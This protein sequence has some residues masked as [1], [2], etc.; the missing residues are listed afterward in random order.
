METGVSDELHKPHVPWIPSDGSSSDSSA[1]DDEWRPS[2]RKQTRK[3]NP[4]RSQA[5]KLI[6]KRRK[7]AALLLQK[8]MAQESATWSSIRPQD[9]ASTSSL[10]Q[11]ASLVPPTQSAQRP[12]ARAVGG[13]GP[14]PPPLQG[15]KA[16]W[17]R[18]RV[19][20]LCLAHQRD[21]LSRVLLCREAIRYP[22]CWSDTTLG[23]SLPGKGPKSPLKAKNSGKAPRTSLSTSPRKGKVPLEVRHAQPQVDAWSVA[24][25]VGQGEEPPCHNGSV[26]AAPSSSLPPRMESPLRGECGED[27]ANPGYER[28]RGPGRE[29]GVPSRPKLR[30]TLLRRKNAVVASKNTQVGQYSPLG[31]SLHRGAK[32]DA[33]PTMVATRAMPRMLSRGNYATHSELAEHGSGQRPKAVGGHSRSLGACK[34]PAKLRLKRSN[35]ADCA[36][37][38]KLRLKQ[39]RLLQQLDGHGGDA[40]TANVAEVGD[41]SASLPRDVP[42]ECTAA[43]LHSF[44]KFLQ[45]ELFA[46]AKRRLAGQPT[47]VRPVDRLDCTLPAQQNGQRLAQSLAL[48]RCRQRRRHAVCGQVYASES[49]A[50][51]PTGVRPVDRLDCTLPAQQNGQRLAQSLALWR[52]R[53]RRRHAVCGQVYASERGGRGSRHYTSR[54]LHIGSNSDSCDCLMVGCPGCHF[55]CPK[56]GSAKCGDECRSNRSYVYEHLELDGHNGLI[57]NPLLG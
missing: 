9:S 10:A 28:L 39:E 3:V 48:W 52:C 18:H 26:P 17:Q 6:W 45:A 51:Q 30:P 2:R 34:L 27:S 37:P 1:G 43:V 49:L 31:P 57:Q 55:P 42:G 54:G 5:T 12:A 7:A 8:Q 20:K 21:R 32:M 56:C 15:V 29:P 38:A 24:R 53:Q 4:L 41:S 14:A 25:G 19:A 50:G 36:M 35:S 47:G 33:A 23:S 11:A 46:E 16:N 13:P 22:I 44:P 40:A